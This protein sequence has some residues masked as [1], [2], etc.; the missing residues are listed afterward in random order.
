[1]DQ[2]LSGQDREI[3]RIFESKAII[4]GNALKES[5]A[6]NLRMEKWIDVFE[7]WSKSGI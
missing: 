4:L 7:T 3:Q 6:T 1:M 5:G 2:G